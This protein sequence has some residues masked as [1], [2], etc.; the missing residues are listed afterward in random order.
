[1]HGLQASW[2]KA[3]PL[4]VF[5]SKETL[6]GVWR[7]KPVDFL[8][9]K[10]VQ[11]VSHSWCDTLVTHHVSE[12]LHRQKERKRRYGKPGLGGV[13]LTY[14]TSAQKTNLRKTIL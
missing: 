5:I 9:M 7:N 12:L 11:D 3:C 4:L 8:D 13:E 2:N 6:S 10:L 14:H 1:M